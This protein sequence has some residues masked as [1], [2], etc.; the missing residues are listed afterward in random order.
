MLLS[1]IQTMSLVVLRAFV[2]GF[3]GILCIAT[4]EKLYS[5]A[6]ESHRV[7]TVVLENN[8]PTP[9][10]NATVIVQKVEIPIT[11]EI[12][13]YTHENSI[14]LGPDIP[15]NESY[16]NAKFHTW[17]GANAVAATN[18]C[19]KF[20]GTWKTLF[21]HP[22]GKPIL[23]QTEYDNAKKIRSPYN[24]LY[25][26]KFKWDFSNV[27]N[28]VP[29]D[30]ALI[31]GITNVIMPGWE[32]H[33]GH[34]IEATMGLFHFLIHEK[35]FPWSANMDRLM[36]LN[37]PENDLEYNRELLNIIL[38][39]MDSET[40]ER[41]IIEHGARRMQQN[42]C[43]EKAILIGWS[44]HE[45]WGGL[46][47]SHREADLFR[48]IAWNYYNIDPSPPV[49]N[50]LDNVVTFVI[51]RATGG[52]PGRRMTN[53]AQV[54]EYIKNEPWTAIHNRSGALQNMSL[55]EQIMCMRETDILIGTHGS[56]LFNSIFLPRHSVVIELEPGMILETCFQR[57]A[58]SAGHA[59]YIDIPPDHSHVKGWK[60]DSWK[61]QCY[62]NELFGNWLD[63]ACQIIKYFDFEVDTKRLGSLLYQ[64]KFVINHVKRLKSKV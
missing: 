34:W 46:F 47:A 2:L 61:A 62:D 21:F 51:N 3:I 57:A 6:P 30:Y 56:G 7:R 26:F 17:A 41:L 27:Q 15:F 20:E 50:N 55:K 64:G 24:F 4:F 40:R 14:P 36:L 37:T 38:S 8:C 9:Q 10:C 35:K 29:K 23:N 58:V 39:V 12:T 60:H 49:R 63:E 16:T 18:I 43:L 59:Y 31:P 1:E 48:T 25:G 45:D 19:F 28:T 54:V 5:L 42:F 13:H 52:N 44:V 33:I 11:N 53:H 22:P 32:H